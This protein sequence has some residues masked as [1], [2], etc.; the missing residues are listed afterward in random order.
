MTEELN[1]SDMTPAE[2]KEVKD[3]WIYE[4]TLIGVTALRKVLGDC[5]VQTV[6]RMVDDNDLT[7]YKRFPGRRGS[8][9]MFRL[10]DVDKYIES[11]KMINNYD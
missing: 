10:T 11:I 2:I 1:W 5:S 9:R 7:V 3:K 4:H 6:D 8:P